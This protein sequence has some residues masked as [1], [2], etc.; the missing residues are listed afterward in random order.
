[1]FV[2]HYHHQTGRIS[3]WG[4]GDS[5]VSHF[6]DHEIVRFDEDA[7]TIDPRR[8]KIDVA[9][10]AVVARTTDEMLD[11]LRRDITAAIAAEL[12]ATDRYMVPDRPLTE[13]QREAWKAYRQA[14]RELKGDA[15]A[16]VAAWPFRPDGSDAA[17]GLEL[18][19]KEIIS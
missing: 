19:L 9:S 15:A 17:A 12:D 7:M 13:Q 16:M 6:A 5:D 14:L 8:D 18:R 3:A 11:D 1:M 10:L 2:I 4:T